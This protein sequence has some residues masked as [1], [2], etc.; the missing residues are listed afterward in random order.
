MT[1]GVS[2]IEQ[3]IDDIAVFNDIVPALLHIFPHFSDLLLASQFNQVLI[4]HHL[5]PDE[6]ALKVRMNDTCGLGGKGSLPVCPGP[7]LIRSNS[8]KRDEAKGFVAKHGQP[9]QGRLIELKLFKKGLALCRI[10]LAKFLF[11]LGR[12]SNP[13]EVLLTKGLS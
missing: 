7:Y 13:L 10:E 3:K 2:D 1:G 6:P 11:N 9:V 8:E 4:F 5:C 12:N